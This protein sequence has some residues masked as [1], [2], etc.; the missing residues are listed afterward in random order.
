MYDMFEGALAALAE[1]TRASGQNHSVSRS[2]SSLPS[3]PLRIRLRD[4]SPLP[5]LSPPSG[6]REAR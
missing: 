4:P 3:P 6:D 1:D 2:S 5:L